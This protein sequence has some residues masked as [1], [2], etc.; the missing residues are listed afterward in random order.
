V[1][2][3]VWLRAFSLRY[4]EAHRLTAEAS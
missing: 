3:A 2:V 4:L 1:P